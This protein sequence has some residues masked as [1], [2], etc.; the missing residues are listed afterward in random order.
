MCNCNNTWTN[1]CLCIF[2]GGFG[3]YLRWERISKR[4]A[5]PSKR[6]GSSMIIHKGST[7]NNHPFVFFIVT[8][9]FDSKVF[10]H[11]ILLFY[12][13][14]NDENVHDTYD[15]WNAAHDACTFIAWNT[16]QIVHYC[17]VGFLIPRDQGKRAGHFEPTM[18]SDWKKTQNI[19]IYIY[20]YIYML[21]LYA[22]KMVGSR[23]IIYTCSQTHCHKYFF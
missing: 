12:C 6:I 19:Y 8:S 23:R 9:Y 16:T 20:I 1:L 17:L 5:P 21:I 22:F 10:K 13:R 18:Q 14:I 11:R 7:T 2:D 4:G 3:F 15:Y